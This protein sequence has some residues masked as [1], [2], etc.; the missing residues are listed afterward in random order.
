MYYISIGFVHPRISSELGAKINDLYP[1]GT[2]QADTLITINLLN[3]LTDIKSNNNL[4]HLYEDFLKSRAIDLNSSNKSLKNIKNIFNA[5]KDHYTRK[6]KN[7]I[8][9]YLIRV[10]ENEVKDIIKYWKTYSEKV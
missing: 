5:F 2:S 3:K 6:T 1:V 10:E 4:D 9:F 8:K 7:A